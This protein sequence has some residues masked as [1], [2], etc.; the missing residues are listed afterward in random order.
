[1]NPVHLVL[2]LLPCELLWN[3][4][5]LSATKLRMFGIPID[6]PTNVLGDNDSDVKSASRVE[7]RLHKKH[8]CNLLF[9]MVREAC[10][11]GW[12]HV[13]WEPT[14]TNIADLFTMVLDTAQRRKLLRFIFVKGG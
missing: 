11:V 5:L 3:A 13:G 14:S 2:S 12:I 8:N 10:A 6:G 1:L 4:L 7:A 9:H